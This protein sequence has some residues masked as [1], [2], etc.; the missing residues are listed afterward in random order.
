[1]HTH[2][3]TKVQTVTATHKEPEVEAVLTSFIGRERRDVIARGECVFCDATDV[4]SR[5]ADES[6]RREY[7]ISGI[8]PTCWAAM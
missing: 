1:M 4:P 5:L 2:T 6:D 8:C 3:Q 7:A